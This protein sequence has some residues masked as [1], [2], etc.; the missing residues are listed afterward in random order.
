M[1]LVFGNGNSSFS[2]VYLRL[3][4]NEILDFEM[5]LNQVH[6]YIFVDI[7]VNYKDRARALS[8]LKMKW[9]KRIL[10]SKGR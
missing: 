5:R 4:L 7:P 9:L 3:T 10:V 6:L 2:V 1:Q 8:L